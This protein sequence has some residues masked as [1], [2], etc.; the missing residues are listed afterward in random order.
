MTPMTAS[1]KRI[2]S[3]MLT[4]GRETM[5]GWKGFDVVTAA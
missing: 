4:L 1:L 3:Y 5:D 2:L